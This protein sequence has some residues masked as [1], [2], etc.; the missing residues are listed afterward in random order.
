[1]SAAKVFFFLSATSVALAQTDDITERLR[2]T[3][4]GT[5]VCE[6]AIVELRARH[7][8]AVQHLL[9]SAPS[10]GGRSIAE[11]D[12]LQGVMAFLQGNMKT[13]VSHFD[14]AQRLAPLSERDVFTE[15]MALTSVGRIAEA[16]R[17]LQQLNQSHPDRPIYI[18]W[19][20]R[21]DF[22]EHRYEDAVAK[23][24]QSLALDPNSARAWDSLGLAYDMQGRADE[25]EEAFTKAAALNRRQA[26]PSPWPAHDLGY[27]LLRANRWPEAEADLRE[28]LRYD[29]AFAQAHYHLA[30]TLEKEGRE[31]DAIAEYSIAVQ[32][33]AASAEA[34]YSLAELYRKLHR[35]PEATA[36][37]A[38]YKRRK[39]ALGNIDQS[40]AIP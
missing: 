31:S 26:H 1:M 10:A 40:I 3:L 11:R 21:L 38:E 35:E 19:L 34:C 18:Y 8:D 37:F 22:D 28:S 24:R 33:D 15:A 9:E 27:W 32:N 14:A 2:R 29:P 13:A 6:Q 20:G 16:R 17:L 25:A 5:D 12:S 7:F 4:A 30:R 36:M 23:L 39:Q